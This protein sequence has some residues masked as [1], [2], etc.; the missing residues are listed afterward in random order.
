MPSI[1]ESHEHP[2]YPRLS[3]PLRHKSR[4]YQGVTFLDGRKVQKSL[5]TGEPV[6]VRC[7]SGSSST[8]SAS[9]VTLNRP[10]V[11]PSSR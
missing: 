8:F 9:F 3:V 7:Q 5:K 10:P 1:L 2:K 6:S 11:L 4:F